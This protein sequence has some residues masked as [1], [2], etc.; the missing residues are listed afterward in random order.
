[1][2][3][4]GAAA[5]GASPRPPL[6]DR[7]LASP[8]FQRWAAAF[9]LTRP[10]ARRRAGALFDLCA[11]FVYSQVLQSAVR[12][13][14]CEALL[15][16]PQP[17]DLLAHR[18]TLPTEGAA[19]LLRATSAL[20][21]TECRSDGRFALGKLGAA[22]AGNPGVAVMVRHHALLYDDLRDPVALLRGG[23]CHTSLQR[24]WPYAGH[25]RPEDLSAEDVARYSGLMAASLPLV[26]AD[27]LAAYRFERHRCLLDLGGGDGAFLS[28]VGSAAP[29]LQLLLF[30]LPA[31]A[32]RA[33]TRFAREGLADRAMALGGDL[34]TGPWPIGADVVSLIRVIHDHDDDTALAILQGAR[35]ALRSGG[36]LVLAEPMAETPGARSVGAY[37]EFYLL[38]MGSGR[39]RTAAE[40]A[41]L[42]RRAGFGRVR[43]VATRQPMLVRLLVGRC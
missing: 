12:L 35:Q 30:D 10:V 43:A 9:P 3:A 16:G 19:R 5:A 38:A 26:A 22:L 8:R 36:T 20:G 2:T 15:E 4:A 21:L 18:M 1:V 41:A 25:D 27:V 29:D 28:A 31:V 23:P 17:L 37:F 40:L 7:L 42:M 39:P 11:G 34:R 13:G 33:R 24:L 14:L 32:D 6:R